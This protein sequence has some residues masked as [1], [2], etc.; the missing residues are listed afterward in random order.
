MKNVVH[1][2]EVNINSSNNNITS[3][4]ALVPTHPP[5]QWLQVALSPEGKA[6][7]AWSWPLIHLV[8]RLRMPGAIPLPL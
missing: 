5:V 4:P 8:P 3:R 1:L 2:K 6:A 7:E